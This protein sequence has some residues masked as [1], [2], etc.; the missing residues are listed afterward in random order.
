M[1]DGGISGMIRDAA[2]RGTGCETPS[3]RCFSN[4]KVAKEGSEQ[5]A[6]AEQRLGSTKAKSIGSR[7]E[8]S[9]RVQES[10]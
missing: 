7:S 4:G 1:G 5:F 2:F 8:V 9:K 3:L 10:G 6:A